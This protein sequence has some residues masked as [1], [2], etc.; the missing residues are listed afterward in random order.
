MYILLVVE[1]CS[2]WYTYIE[3]CSRTC[4]SNG[5]CNGMCTCKEHIVTD[6]HVIEGVVVGVH[7]TCNG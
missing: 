1:K 4:T 5:K 3:R 2:C 7:V 6:I